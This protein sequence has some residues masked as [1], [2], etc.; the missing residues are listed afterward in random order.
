MKRLN[1]TASSPKAWSPSC[2]EG[3]DSLLLSDWEMEISIMMK[4]GSW[5]ILA[6]GEDGSWTTCR[7]A[8]M[9]E[10]LGAPHKTTET[11]PHGR[12][13]RKWQVMAVSLL[14]G[15]EAPSY[16][17]DVLLQDICFLLRGGSRTL[18]ED[19]QGLSRPQKTADPCCFLLCTS[20]IAPEK[21]WTISSMT[22]WLW[23]WRSRAWWSRWNWPGPDG[24]GEGLEEWA[25]SAGQQL[26]VKLES[27]AGF[28]FLCPCDTCWDLTTARKRPT[29]L[30]GGK[31][32]LPTG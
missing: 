21:I 11:E 30:S 5:W 6:P 3:G 12:T 17:P 26:S 27:A 29:Q 13:R 8:V 7:L 15:T 24:E 18:F 25:Y 20:M 32:C 31:A 10:V 22:T 1:L 28:W 16:W 2:T 23:E 9:N 19:W 14:Q 4:F